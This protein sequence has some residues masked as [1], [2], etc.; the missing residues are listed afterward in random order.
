VA[1]VKSKEAHAMLAERLSTD[2]NSS[3]RFD[4]LRDLAA[5]F[6]AGRADTYGY[7]PSEIEAARLAMPELTKGAAGAVLPRALADWY[8]SVGRVAKL[9]ASQNRLHAPDALRLQDDVVIIYTEN[10][11]CAFWGIRVADL[12]Q[13]DPPVV[14]TEDT[15]WR[16]EADTLSEFALT[17]GLTELCLSGGKSCCAGCLDEIGIA[18]LQSATTLL[19]I[20]TLRWPPTAPGQFLATDDILAL[21]HGEFIFAVSTQSRIEERVARLVAPGTV[22]WTHDTGS[23]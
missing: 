19:P 6:S 17:V 15:S 3:A 16:P 13:H 20:R 7:A 4:V 1:A 5:L 12:V 18:S 14:W 11:G 22:E 23:Q 10:Q 21:L 9:T 2:L 8:R